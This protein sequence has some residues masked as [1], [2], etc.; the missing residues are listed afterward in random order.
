[1]IDWN[2]PDY[3][4]NGYFWNSLK[5][6]RIECADAQHDVSTTGYEFVGNDT[7]DVPVSACEGFADCRWLDLPTDRRRS[8]V[9][10]LPSRQ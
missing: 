10:E 1:M 6:V 7:Q 9:V 3:V 5:S 2:D 8:R 4:A